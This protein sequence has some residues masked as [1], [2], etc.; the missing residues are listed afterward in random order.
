MKKAGE[1]WR[2]QSAEEQAR[3]KQQAEVLKHAAHAE[4]DRDESNR[5]EVIPYCLSLTVSIML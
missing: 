5:E 3:Y 2:Q 4:F 1:L